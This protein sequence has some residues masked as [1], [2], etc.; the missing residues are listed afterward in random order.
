M[1]T[2]YSISVALRL[3]EHCISAAL[4]FK[5]GPSRSTK[6]ENLALTVR[7]ATE[8]SLVRATRLM[9]RRYEYPKISA[10]LKLCKN[11]N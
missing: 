8:A 7:E 11:K 4:W 1:K 5:G 9:Y 10:K 6:C 2:S 3:M